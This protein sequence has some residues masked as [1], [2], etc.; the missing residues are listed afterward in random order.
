MIKKYNKTLK[1]KSYKLKGG[2]QKCS[3][4]PNK[5]DTIVVSHG[6]CNINKPDCF[7]NPQLPQLGRNPYTDL[8]TLSEIV[9]SGRYCC[10]NDKAGSG[11]Q[12]QIGGKS[13]LSD[14]IIK[15]GEVFKNQKNNKYK[16][17]TLFVMNGRFSTEG[18]E[19]QSADEIKTI[20]K[21]NKIKSNIVP[22]AT[23]GFKL[24]FDN[25]KLHQQIASDKKFM[26]VGGSLHKMS[27]GGYYLALDH[28]PPGG[29]SNVKG[30]DN[31]CPPMFSGDLSG[32]TD[33][34]IWNPLCQ[35]PY[36]VPP[37]G[38]RKKRKT[39]RRKKIKRK[40]KTKTK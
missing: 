10:G 26:K 35:N 11:H 36:A 25:Q 1:K 20:L 29:L 3:V 13:S 30:Y 18:I 21:K 38:G 39:I 37:I 14:G 23:G 32:N 16:N 33:S 15:I 40:N 19:K 5:Q 17:I 8:P 31:C 27:G 24:Y 12:N 2:E 7:N 4:I 22:Y 6:N 9:F 34:T 28:C